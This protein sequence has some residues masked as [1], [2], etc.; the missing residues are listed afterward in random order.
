[1]MIRNG[2][3]KLQTGYISQDSRVS[4][5]HKCSFLVFEFAAFVCERDDACLHRDFWGDA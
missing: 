5:N 3:R 1:M 4:G 2:S